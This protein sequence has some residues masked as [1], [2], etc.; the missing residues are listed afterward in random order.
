[1]YE[2][3][4]IL[5]ASGVVSVLIL[6]LSNYNVNKL[7]L[8]FSH[9][10]SPKTPVM[11]AGE[12]YIARKME[13]EYMRDLLQMTIARIYK[14]FEEGKISEGDRDHLVD[15]FRRKL[16]EIERE[17]NEVSLFAEL[18]S[19]E[20]EYKKLVEDFE[21]RRRELE[22]RIRGIRER[23][24]IRVVKREERP[25]EKKE[26]VRERKKTSVRR[27]A[28]LSDIIKELTDMMKKLEEE[29]G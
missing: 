18:E 25:V 6:L 28:D 13:L 20:R 17:L 16:I 1:M 21:R 3:L 9:V 22:D 7:V 10:E 19:L 4:I 5:V 26:V 15:K 24:N 14:E 29:E 27:E 23:L 8:N 11:A 2:E 12:G